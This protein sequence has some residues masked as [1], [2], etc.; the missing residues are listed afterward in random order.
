VIR[1]LALITGWLLL[2]HAALAGMYWALLIVP[3]S[4]AWMLALSTVLAAGI[5]A[6]A[7]GLY[8]GTLLAWD[9]RRRVLPALVSG[10]RRSYWAI[11]AALI[12][13]TFWWM[14][15]RL[16]DWHAGARGPIDAWLM[17]KFGWAN[18]PVL[19]AILSALAVAVQWI[20]GI[21]LGLG[22]LASGA[23]LGWAGVIGTRWLQRSLD[24]RTL[25]LIAAIEIVLVFLPWRHLSW[26]PRGLP[27]SAEAV[28]VSLKLGTFAVL[29]SLAAA[30]IAWTIVRALAG[31]RQDSTRSAGD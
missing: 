28:F 25:L 13:I 5:L 6:G 22:V 26:R 20:L 3:E 29:V 16:H 12:F 1:R 10:F 2:G 23:A 15:A 30:L 17:A 4:S 18:A 19:H 24:P 14:G 31:W 21:A 7:S 9:A 27:V 8:A 11:P